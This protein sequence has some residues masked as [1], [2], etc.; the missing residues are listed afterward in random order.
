MTT[1]DE[2]AAVIQAVV[3]HLTERLLN[4]HFLS[5][6]RKV[7]CTANTITSSLKQKMG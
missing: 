3:G 1:V 7:T 6:F 2:I 4:E 5:S